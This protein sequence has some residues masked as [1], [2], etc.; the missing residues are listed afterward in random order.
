MPDFRIF[1]V[2]DGIP[3]AE[4]MIT[5]FSGDRYNL[6][7]DLYDLQR[8]SSSQTSLANMTKAGISVLL[9]TPGMLKYLNTTTEDE[10]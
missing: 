9:V 2:S 5:K 3:V 8:R 10:R 1:H 7:V 4:S 6:T